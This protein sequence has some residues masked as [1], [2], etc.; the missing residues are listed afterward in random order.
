MQ[1]RVGLQNGAKLVAK[2]LKIAI[3]TGLQW[4]QNFSASV[5]GF[6]WKEKRCIVTHP[7]VAG[8][9]SPAASVYGTPTALLTHLG[10]FL[11]RK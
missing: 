11:F 1:V 5:M 9:R 2:R 4:G 8:A 6:E 7:E 3:Y 10:F